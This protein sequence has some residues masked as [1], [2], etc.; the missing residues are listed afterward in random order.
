MWAGGGLALNQADPLQADFNE[1]ARSQGIL[2]SMISVHGYLRDWL[3]VEA[4]ASF[5]RYQFFLRD[6]NGNVIRDVG[7]RLHIPL[8]FRL[9]PLRYF[10]FGAGFYGSYRIG[11]VRRESAFEIS[12]RTSAFDSGEHGMQGVVGAH[13]PIYGGYW[14]YL[15]YRMDYSLTPRPSENRIWNTFSLLVFARL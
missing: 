13:I 11:S 1:S 15:D 5:S 3:I 4:A 10:S 14:V 2:G 6:G 7:K 12:E 9:T 8:V